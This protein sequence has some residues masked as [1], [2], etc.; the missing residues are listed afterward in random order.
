[1]LVILN[2]PI[3]GVITPIGGTLLIIAWLM[4]TYSIIKDK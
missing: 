3:L 2:I 1:L 4:A